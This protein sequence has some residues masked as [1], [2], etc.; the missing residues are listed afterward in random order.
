MTQLTASW[1]NGPA[2]QVLALLMDGG[3]QAYYVGGCVRNALLQTSVSDLDVSTDAHPERVIELSK[4]AGLNAIPTGIDHGTITVVAEGEPVE[5]TTFRRDVAT[6]GR[7]ATVAFADR[8]EDDA[9][10]RDFTMNAL[11]CDIDG[12]VLD[13]L[14]GLCDLRAGRVRFIDD[15]AQRIAEDYLRI[16]RFFRF[17]AWYGSNGIEAEGLAACA[18]YA[19]GLDDLSSERI[20]AELSK[21][22]SALDPAPAIA[23]MGHSGVLMRVLAGAAPDILTVLVHLEQGYEIDPIRRLVALGGDRSR[24]RLSNAQIRQIEQT[25]DDKPLPELAYRHGFAAARDRHLIECAGLSQPVDQTLLADLQD[26][27]N[28]TFPITA[29]DLMPAIQGAAL[30]RALREAEARWIASGF[31]LGKDDLLG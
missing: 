25:L 5:V 28:Q 26:A 24:L 16:L 4:A 22:L 15:P 7:R 20:T 19:D 21:L 9:R 29:A 14:G 11:Y 18:E 13:P 30:G 31:V 2:R 1:L 27:A 23:A 8:I 6:D 10:R 12:H 3:H 17:S